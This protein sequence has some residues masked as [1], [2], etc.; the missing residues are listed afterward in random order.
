L[1]PGKGR[2]GDHGAARGGENAEAQAELAR[3]FFE[4]GRYDEAEQCVEAALRLNPDQLQGRWIR[5]ELHRVGQPGEA[6]DA[7]RR[8]IACYNEHDVR[9]A[10]SLRWIGLA[11]GQ[12]ARW[13]R[14]SDQFKLL[15]P[16]S[17]NRRRSRLMRPT[18]RRCMKRVFCIWRNT[19]SATPPL[20]SARRSR[21]I[22]QAAEVLAA[23][24]RLAC[25]IATSK[26]AQRSVERA[27]ENNPRFLRPGSQ[28]ELAWEN[29]DPA[30]A[31]GFLEDRALAAQP[32]SEGVAGAVRGLLRASKTGCPR[33]AMAAGLPR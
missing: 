25:S 23:V 8:L 26:R 4:R 1:G 22:P 3:A 17:T 9:D 2:R 27:L 15:V 20:P 11:A 21:S 16:G 12:Y 18:G 10:E 14:Q 30:G 28:A 6:E 19:T 24:A 13:N 29:F 32:A 7:Y 33:R 5:G 31:C